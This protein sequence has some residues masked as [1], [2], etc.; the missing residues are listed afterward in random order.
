M[1]ALIKATAGHVPIYVFI[2][3]EFSWY[4]YKQENT[5]YVIY[6]TQFIRLNYAIFRKIHKE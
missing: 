3:V 4:W 2:N 6:Y 1:H 5:D